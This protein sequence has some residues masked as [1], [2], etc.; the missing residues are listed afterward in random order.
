MDS[1]RNNGNFRRADYLNERGNVKISKAFKRFS[2]AVP[3][4]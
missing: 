2:I 3:K 1:L 4:T